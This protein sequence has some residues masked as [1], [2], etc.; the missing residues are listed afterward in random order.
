MYRQSW[1]GI[2]AFAALWSL[3]FA[4]PLRN[5]DRARNAT[6]NYKQL[7]MRDTDEFDPED[8]SF[9]TKMAAIGDSYSA[10]IGAGDRLDGPGGKS[11]PASF[12]AGK[13]MH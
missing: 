8:L 10:G 4:N 5:W 9:I 2:V 1:H 3:S 6:M 7:M 11:T 13:N 12:N